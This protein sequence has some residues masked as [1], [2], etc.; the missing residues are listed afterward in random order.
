MEVGG[1]WV[2]SGWGEGRRQWEWVRRGWH[3]GEEQTEV[4]GE[5]VG[6]GWCTVYCTYVRT[7]SGT[8]VD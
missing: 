5:W 2:G 3:V 4:G 7:F 1:E 6:S 8:R